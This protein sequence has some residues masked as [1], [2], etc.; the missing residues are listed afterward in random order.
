VLINSDGI[1]GLEN[2][3]GKNNFFLFDGNPITALKMHSSA[4][5]PGFGGFWGNDSGYHDDIA[6]DR[7]GVNL[8]SPVEAASPND[9]LIG[10]TPIE[11]L[12]D[13]FLSDWFG[14]YNTTGAPW[15][16]HAQHGFVY[17]NPGSTNDSIF[18]Y[19]D[20]MQSWWWTNETDYPFMYGFGIPAD[21]AGTV[22]GDAWLWYF[23]GTSGPRNFGV[24]TGAEAGGFL[25]FN[26]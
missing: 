21:N 19:D 8:T 24:V 14:A 22:A 9:P 3:A 18:F 4:G 5:V 10:G 6:I 12:E 17:H 26:P 11:G 15:I 1:I 25:F 20:A 2:S 13:W 23:E 7:G 16:F